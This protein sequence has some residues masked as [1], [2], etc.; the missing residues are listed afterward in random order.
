VYDI[1]KVGKIADFLI[2][3]TIGE[4]RILNIEQR[5]KE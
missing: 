4:K 1:G 2:K 5:N 3:I